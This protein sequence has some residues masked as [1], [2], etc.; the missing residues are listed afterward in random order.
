[1]YDIKFSKSVNKFIK[2]STPNYQKKFIQSFE[3]LL[4]NPFNSIQ[5]IKP[6]QNKKGHFRLRIGKFRFLYELRK[7][8]LLIYFYKADSRGQVYK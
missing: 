2:K 6:L 8:I 7:D 4:L 3:T 1:M 5:D